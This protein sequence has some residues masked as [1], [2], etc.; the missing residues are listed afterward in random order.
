M[1]SM[2]S[3]CHLSHWPTGGL[4]ATLLMPSRWTGTFGSATGPS[5]VAGLR[6]LNMFAIVL[7][8]VINVVVFVQRLRSLQEDSCW[9]KRRNEQG[10]N[11]CRS[12]RYDLLID[13]AGKNHA[14]TSSEQSHSNNTQ[15]TH[16]HVHRSLWCLSAC[17]DSDHA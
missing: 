13:T 4:E 16:A 6:R 5:T 8:L 7:M 12:S 9:Q 15:D 2:S 17:F 10:Q 11:E 14:P 3:Q 1:V